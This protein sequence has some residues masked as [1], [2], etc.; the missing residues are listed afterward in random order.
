MLSRSGE[1]W[2]PR[3]S[4]SSPTLP[5]TATRAGSTAST[6][7]RRKRAPPTPP[8]RTT[9]PL[10]ARW[11]LPPR[12]EPGDRRPARVVRDLARARW[13]ESVHRPCLPARG[14][15]DQGDEGARGRPR[16]DRVRPGAARDR[17]GDRVPLAR[18]ARDGPDRR[19]R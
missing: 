16:P 9:I 1:T 7:P 15:A 11:T 12:G 18:A 14:R 13:G 19:A 10:I 8:D 2:R 3:T 6:R 4:R 17:P 5:I